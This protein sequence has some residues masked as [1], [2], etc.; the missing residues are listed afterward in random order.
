MHVEH[1][2]LRHMSIAEDRMK[3]LAKGK[4]NDIHW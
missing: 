4:I 2:I 1:K 3:S